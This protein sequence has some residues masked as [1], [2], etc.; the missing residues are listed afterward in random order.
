MGQR[1]FLWLAS[2]L[3]LAIFVLANSLLQ[4]ALAGWR[5]DFSEGRQF[6]LSDGTQHTLDT[7]NEPVELTFVYSRRVGQN[8]PAVRAYAQRVRE[9]LQSFEATAGRAIRLTEIDP[10]PFSVAEDEA[11]ANGITAVQTDDADPLYFGL[12]GRNAVDDEL[13]IPFLAPEREGTLEYDLTRLIARLD[14]PELATVGIIT[15]LPGMTGN[16]DDSGSFIL[17][18]IARSYQIDAL[19]TGFAAI[20][21]RVDVLILAHASQ[22]TPY[23]TYLVDQ[24]VLDKGRALVFIDPAAKALAADDNAEIGRADLGLLGQAW[25]VELS[26]DAVADAAHALPVTVEDNGRLIELGQPLFIG[27]PSNLM[28]QDDLVTAPL[29]R[30]VNFGAPG[31]LSAFPPDG[32]SFRAL[33]R[34]DEAPSYID[35]DFARRDVTPRDVLEVYDAEDGQL[36][37][38]GR[39]SGRLSTAFPDGAPALEED[40]LADLVPEE[41]GPHLAI[42]RDPAEIILIADG[43]VLEDG[44]YIDPQSGT[45]VGD[46]ANLVLNALDNLAG[47]AE[48]LELRSRTPNLRPMRR[49][50]QMREAAEEA[51]FDEQVQLQARLVQAQQRLEELQSIGAGGGFFAGDLEAD[52][53]PDERAELAELR[54]TVVETRASLR[55]IERDFRRNIDGLERT[56]RTLNIW[57]GPLIVL[58]IGAA[59]WWRRERRTKA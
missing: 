41:T 27:M 21:D 20:P 53:A 37:L 36:V 16:G 2:G 34:T 55:G 30:R 25:G 38:A 57:T 56:L 35:A 7:L 19:G 9:L 43:D 18:E 47:G 46:N 40:D 50:E 4:P 59:V 15:D 28:A 13:V 31:A 44:F 23:Q 52:L 58:L 5:A 29:S 12:I 48:L 24:F 8:Y 39:L 14:R 49:V 17:Q 26:T 45:A 3:V 1:A 54:E 22:L 10:T 6:T 33:I 51:Y 32:V 11:L 42:S